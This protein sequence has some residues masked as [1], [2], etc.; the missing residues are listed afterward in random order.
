LLEEFPSMPNPIRTG[1]P[2]V[3][4]TT[5][6]NQTYRVQSG[7]TLS[8]IAQRFGTTVDALMSANGLSSAHHIRAGE[9]LVIPG[10]NAPAGGLSAAAGRSFTFQELWPV[11]Q[12]AA[13]QH[14]ADARVMAAIVRQE[15]S[16]INHRVHRDGT[17]HGL[18]GLDDNGRLPEFERWSGLR[19][20]RG[21]SAVVIP[22]ERQLEFLAKTIAD[23]T[24][25]Y[26]DS[27]SA[28]RE[29]HRGHGSMNDR[30]GMQYQALIEDHLQALF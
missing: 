1:V 14:G 16:F 9:S 5:T 28:A 18:I 10:G 6:G 7:D 13:N 26:G 25:R 22:P 17:G 8:G 12:A 21:R 23:S 27:L 15:S 2:R 4:S 20:G 19:V 11:I 30:R 29:W 24:R 3:P